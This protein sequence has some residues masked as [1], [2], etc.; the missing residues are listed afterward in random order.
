M[1][2]INLKEIVR[3]EVARLQTVKVESD[4]PEDYVR[5][6][7]NENFFVEPEVISGLIIDA[8]KEFDYRRYPDN[9]AGLAVRAIS[10]FL[11]VEESMVYVGN[12]LDEVMNTLFR[13]YLRRGSKVLIVEPTFGMYSYFTNLY[14]GE[15]KTVLLN[16]DFSLNVEQ[17]IE[18]SKDEISLVIVCSPNN[19][20]GNQFPRDDLKRIL[21]IDAL[22]VLDEAYVQFADYSMIDDVWN[23]ENLAV[24]RTFSKV[25]GL[26]GIRCGYLVSNPE[27]IEYMNRATPPFHVNQL[28]Q[29][30]VKKALSMWSYFEGKVKEVIE[31]RERL[32]KALA[33]LDGIKVYPSKTNFILVKIVKEGVTPRIL[34]KKLMERKILIRD[35]SDKPLLSDCIR[36]TVGKPEHNELLVSA[37]EKCLES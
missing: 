20:T 26:A 37:L 28:T 25:F 14:G 16:P 12:G 34:K 11:G 27:V 36:I 10:R 33:G 17:I 23:Y 22:V 1:G 31:E 3:E 24:M 35:V 21:E 6:N 2:K 19:P 30:I 5:L 7:M 13:T 9:L 15:L 4:F 8:C 32:R 29:L 18:Q